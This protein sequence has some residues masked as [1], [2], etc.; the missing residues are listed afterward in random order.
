MI[1][2]AVNP[3]L[4]R[5]ARERSGIPFDSLAKRFKRLPEWE[6]G[7]T[8]PTLKQVEAFARA[9]HVPV[10]YLFLTE[11]PEE[12]IPIPDFRTHVAH[13]L[14]RP[15]PDLLDTIYMCQER[16]SW[17][18]DFA[19]VSGRPE[20]DFVGH[21]SLEASPESVAN[22]M[23]ERLGFDP[24]ARRECSTWTDALRLFI[25]QTDE[26]GVLVMVSGVVMS[27][28]RR[29]LDPAEFRGF[30]LSDPVAPLVF[31]NGRDTKAAQ[32]FTL[33]HELAHLWLG[34]SALSN[35]GV[36]PQSGFRREEVWCNAVAAEFLVPLD[37]LR[38]DLRWNE[39]LPEALSRLARAFKVS[40]LVILRRLLDAGWI[41]R[42]RF[43]VAWERE[44]EHLTRLVR[45]GG[46]D[47]YNT[48]L[49]RVSHR[50][51]RAL[52]ASTL[53]GHTLYRDAFRMLGVRKTKTFNKL[54]REVGVIG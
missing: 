36:A 43:N 14:T 1:R 48:T 24:A 12:T 34:A 31:I 37:V 10:G 27:N 20:L 16:Q 7:E 8:R 17:Y 44:I 47:F 15:S 6:D 26:V 18:R 13:E 30:A 11:P 45:G 53:E 23:R 19:R 50:F 3:H 33:A 22:Q 52:V 32:M 5:W 49:A 51:A 2:V 9:V 54:G 42:S 4:L 39:Q 40:K 21:A 29:P 46:G 28:N 41:E 25:R 38:S 35:L